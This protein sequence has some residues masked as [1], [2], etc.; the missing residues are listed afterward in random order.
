MIQ[1]PTFLVE[2]LFEFESD[3]YGGPFVMKEEYRKKFLERMLIV[4][5]I[6]WEHDKH[7][8]WSEAYRSMMN[9][10][11]F[12][13][14]VEFNSHAN[15]DIIADRTHPDRDHL[16]RQY[17]ANTYVIVDEY[18]SPFVRDPERFL[19]ALASCLE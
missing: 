12:A 1:I 15:R 8:R 9:G 10:T 18:M 4:Y 19:E 7:A 6:A 11:D 13:F 5:G 14:A 17:Q 3:P 2:Q 16:I